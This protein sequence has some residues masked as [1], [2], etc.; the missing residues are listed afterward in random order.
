MSITFKS[1]HDIVVIVEF[2]LLMSDLAR[3]VGAG[4]LTVLLLNTLKSVLN[5][6]SD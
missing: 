2:F 3:I 5:K 4:N 6:L 1:I